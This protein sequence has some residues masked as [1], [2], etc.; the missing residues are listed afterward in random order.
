MSEGR[1]QLYLCGVF[2]TRSPHLAYDAPVRS[3][4]P[5]R[6]C[7]RLTAA[8]L[9]LER[10]SRSAGRRSFVA[11]AGPISEVRTFAVK[12]YKCLL[13]LAF[14]HFPFPDD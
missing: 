5:S 3:P 14:L 12:F 1:R 13:S 7:D 6:H 11:L 8:C 2:G 4:G 9:M 10:N